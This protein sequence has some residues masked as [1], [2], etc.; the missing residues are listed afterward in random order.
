MEKTIDYKEL[1]NFW[2]GAVIVREI[3]KYLD[4]R[5]M[6]G[7]I[8]RIDS[9]INHDATMCYISETEPFVLRGPHEHHDQ[10]D[11]F[12]TWGDDNRMI[13][14]LYNKKTNEMKYFI[15]EPNKIYSVTVRPGIV[16]SYRNVSTN[17]IKTLNFPDKLYKGFNK[18]EIIDEIRHEDIV[19]PT[20]NIWVFG[21]NGRLGSELTKQLFDNMGYHTYNVIP[22]LDKFSNDKDGMTQ[23]SIV[24][25]NVL[26]NKKPDDIIINCMAKTNVQEIESNFTFVNFH[27]PKY[28]TEFCVKNKIYLINF[29]TD[30][31]FQ[32]GELS[33]YTKSK[34]LY[35]NWLSNIADDDGVLQGYRLADI[36][37]Y[38]KV[39]RTAN[40]FS[41]KNTDTHNIINKILAKK[42]ERKITIPYGLLIMPTSVESLSK[43]LNEKYITN[44]DKYNQYIGISG[45]AYTFQEFKDN[46]LNCDITVVEFENNK[47]QNNSNLFLNGEFYY[48]INCDA[49]ITKKCEG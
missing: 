3:K 28:L 6:V 41:L 44:L 7:E 30:Y 45:K 17:K 32:T 24:L 46:F 48:E 47:M 29:S 23:L 8:F 1:Y 43:F 20:R 26:E 37:K 11:V 13:Y 25:K 9:D 40:L 14:Q 38:I 19:I 10:S 35:E 36:K 34:M 31:V 33:N 39:I 15:T 42:E 2:N 49:D 18:K 22:I 21:A 5:G 4:P 27:L 12:I 16:H